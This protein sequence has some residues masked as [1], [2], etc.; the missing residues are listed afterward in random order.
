LP[1]LKSLG[2]AGV[3]NLKVNGLA[4]SDGGLS[5]SQIRG[6][7]GAGWELDTEGMSQS[8][9][10]AVDSTQLTNEVTGARQALRS[11]YGVPVNWFSYPS[12]RY[13]QAVV[14]AAQ[15]AKFVGSTTS[16]SGWASPQSDR[17]R[18]PRI[19]VVGGTSA[20]QLL[21]QIASAQ[22]TTSVP[23]SA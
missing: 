1:V 18:L 12:G 13:N 5:D 2:W 19:Q 11:R 9:L 8:D 15:S 22:G 21:S 14:V 6:L 16:V 20:S 4:P 3:E 23:T 7:I 10:T 17:F